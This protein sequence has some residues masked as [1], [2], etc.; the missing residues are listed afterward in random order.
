MGETRSPTLVLLVE[1]STRGAR[2]AS[3]G[4]EALAAGS[5]MELH[6]GLERC[7]ALVRRVIS[8]TEFGVELQQVSHQLK[9]AI[10]RTVGANRVS[11]SPWLGL[12]G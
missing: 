3:W 1:L 4:T 2:V 10:I 12:D 9:L 7:R 11:P 5:V 8:P 6:I